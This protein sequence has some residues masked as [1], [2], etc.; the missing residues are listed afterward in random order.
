MFEQQLQ[1]ELDRVSKT[2]ERYQRAERLV[3]EAGLGTLEPVVARTWLYVPT[4][5]ISVPHHPDWPTRGWVDRNCVHVSLYIPYGVKDLVRDVCF[6]SGRDW[7]KSYAIN[8]ATTHPR[9]T[10]Y[11]EEHWTWQ[12]NPDDPYQSDEI[13]IVLYRPVEEG[14]EVAGCT[15]KRKTYNN[16][17]SYSHLAIVCDLED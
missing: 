9:R 7:L 17:S 3:E 2:K 15:V 8:S 6:A 16:S 4:D 13:R 10:D 11:L 1:R 12:A 5:S 14:E